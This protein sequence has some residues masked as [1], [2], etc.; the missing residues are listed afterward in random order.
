MTNESDF[1][2]WFAEWCLTP[3]WHSWLTGCALSRKKTG[4]T[5][6]LCNDQLLVP[7]ALSSKNLNVDF[8]M[9]FSEISHL[10]NL[11]SSS[12]PFDSLSLCLWVCV[13]VYVCWSL[14]CLSCCLT[15]TEVRWPI[16]DGDRVGRGRESERLD[17]RNCL[18]KT[19][20]TM[21]RR[22]NNGSVKV[23]SPRHCPATCAL[24]NCFFNC[25][26]GQN[27][28]DNVCCT[29]VDEQLGQLEAKDVPTCSAQLHLPTH[30]LFWA[31]LRVQ[32]HLPPLRSFDLAWNP[33][34]VDRFVLCF[35]LGYVLQSGEIAHK[36]LLLLSVQFCLLACSHFSFTGPSIW[37]SFT[38]PSIWNSFTGPSIW[39][40]FRVRHAQLKTRPFS[41]S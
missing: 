20:E 31:K 12:C 8:F 25:C 23:V 17:H 19:G 41:Y 38:G 29:A 5:G 13:H 9:S 7:P 34:S 10:W 27:R 40:S 30:D 16:R 4:M 1:D 28:Q 32:L 39:N 24:S 22:Q 15:S 37:N 36:R 26:A 33:D 6:G 21:D 18:K 14:C 2:M 3:I 11:S 35:L